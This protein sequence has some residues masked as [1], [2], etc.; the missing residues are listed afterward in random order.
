MTPDLKIE[1]DEKLRIYREKNKTALKHQVL[2]VGSSLMEMFP[3]EEMTA[4][5]KLPFAIY[6]RGIGGYRTEDLLAAL[7]T[8]VLDL[9]PR[10]IFIN[11]G[12]ND[13][14]DPDCPISAM[15]ANYDEILNRILLRLPRVEIYLMA[16]YPV[17]Y[18]AAAP[19]MKECLKIRTNAKIDN[20]NHEVALLAAR[21]GLKYID[22]S[23]NLKDENGSLEAEYTI[24]GMHIKPEGYQAILDDVMKYVMTFQ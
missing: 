24:E 16:Y 2:F 5:M 14:S 23:R 6:N 13:L 20:A 12:T 8:C 4:D 22:V 9:E 19:E 3:I 10:R 18:D 17:N 11:I 21:H 7:D 1:T 15:I